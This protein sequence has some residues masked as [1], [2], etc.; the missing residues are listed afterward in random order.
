VGVDHTVSLQS[1]LPASLHHRITAFCYLTISPDKSV[2][3]RVRV[4]HGDKTK[5][6]LLTF[7][8]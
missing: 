6:S 5:L 4:M 2:I 3:A 8:V 7:E 1:A